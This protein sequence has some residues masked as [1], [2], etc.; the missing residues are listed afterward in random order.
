MHT[1]RSTGS[2]SA[3]R[4]ATELGE[5]L[6]ATRLRR[7]MTQSRL[8]VRSGVSERTIRDLELGKVERPR[9]QT[10]LLLARALHM[11]PSDHLRLQSGGAVPATASQLPPSSAAPL[12]GRDRVV[13][14]LVELLT[15]GGHRWVSLVGVAGVGK[16][17]VVA[18]VAR[19]LH[20]A[21]PDPV[22]WVD[23]GA[24]P[25]PLPGTVADL[26]LGGASPR[27]AELAALVGDTPAYLV[28]D[29][30]VPGRVPEVGL[31]EL[32][33]RCPRLRLLTTARV[34]S[35]R[36]EAHTVA[37][38]PLAARGD[39]PDSPATRLLV[40]RLRAQGQDRS[41]PASELRELCDALDGVPAALIAAASWF[42]LYPLPRLV[43]AARRDPFQLTTPAGPATRRVVGD[44]RAAVS[45]TLDG[46]RGSDT[47]LLTALVGAGRS[48]RDVARERG[49]P[50][51][52][53][54]SA[55][56][57]LLQAGLIRPT[58]VP[59]EFRA[60]NMVRSLLTPRRIGQ[61]RR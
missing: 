18:E 56:H 34:P 60:L 9:K 26:L 49:I 12:V 54:A 36:P 51:Q 17:R 10:L 24:S 28:V 21:V 14:G 3:D 40:S 59:G 5:F 41:F 32:L 8:A 29:D 48:V 46:L 52:S 42:P 25:A 35:A 20:D 44:L 27:L 4:P 30:R 22:W 43:E 6:L 50:E 7:G 61:P 53:A 1:A 45:A 15:T 47:A 16:S 2:V 11:S 39:G 37:L 38:R 31:A 13:T 19:A 55:L 33:S 23:P 57:R 58:G